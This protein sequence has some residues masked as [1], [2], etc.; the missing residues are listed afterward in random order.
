MPHDT[1]SAGWGLGL[2]HANVAKS[3]HDARPDT[4]SGPRFG[5]DIHYLAFA[6][7]PELPRV[8]P[9]LQRRFLRALHLPGRA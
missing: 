5:T 7:A 9:V 1:L 3:T 4:G 2:R 8:R 6:R